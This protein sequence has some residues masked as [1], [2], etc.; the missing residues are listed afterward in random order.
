MPYHDV[1]KGDSLTAALLVV[2]NAALR[3]SNKLQMGGAA[4]QND[5][6]MIIIRFRKHQD[7]VSADTANMDR[8]ILVDESQIP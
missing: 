6:F 1:C 5:L 7:I 4:L 3:T 8:Q 2:F